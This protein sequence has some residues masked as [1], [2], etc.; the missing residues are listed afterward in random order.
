MSIY[1]LVP[2]W[3]NACIELSPQGW[4]FFLNKNMPSKPITLHNHSRWTLFLK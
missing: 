4:Q 3:G 1:R 2:F